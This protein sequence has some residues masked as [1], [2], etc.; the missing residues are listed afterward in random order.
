MEQRKRS[1]REVLA[2]FVQ[3]ARG[4]SAA[5]VAGL[6]HRDFKPGNV[7]VGED[8]R[9]R[10]MDFGLARTGADADVSARSARSLPVVG[11]DDEMRTAADVLLGTPAYMAPEQHAG[12]VPDARAD[13]YAWCVALWEALLGRRPFTGGREALAAAKRAGPPTPPAAAV[14]RWLARLLVRGLAVDPERRFASMDAL[15][16]ALER[17][18]ARARVR[19]VALGVLAVVA[20]AV[21]GLAWNRAE[22]AR[23][24]AACEAA[25]ATIAEVWNDDARAG[26][27]DALVG[28]GVSYAAATA[29]RVMPWL[30]AQ[31]Q[32]WQHAR[33]EACLDAD[34]R[35]VW[36]TAVLDRSSWCLD[37]RRMEIEALV[38]DLTHADATSVQKAVSAAAGLTKVDGCRDAA[39]LESLPAPPVERRDEVREVRAALSRVSAFERGRRFAEGLTV[40]RNARERADALGWPPLAAE[41]G[42]REASVLEGKGEYEEAEKAAAEAYFAALRAGAWDGATAGASTLVPIFGARRAQLAD[43]LAWGRHAESVLAHAND[44]EHIDEATLLQNLANAHYVAGEHAQAQALYERALAIFEQALGTDHPDVGTNL[45]NLAGV[46]YS[47]GDYAGARA[48]YERALAI[49]EQAFGPEHPDVAMGLNNLAIVCAATGERKQALA[50]HERALASWERALGPDHPDV[51]ASLNNIANVHLAL[52]DN[53]AARPLYERSR[54]IFERSLGPD[55]PRVAK[56]V[57]NLGQVHANLGEHEQARALYQRALAIRES[58][59][60]RDHPDLAASLA[61]LARAHL[62]ANQASS[63]VPAGVQ[64]HELAARFAF[65]RALVDSG[66]DRARAVKLAEQ[67]RDGWRSDAETNA[68]V[69][70]EVEAWLAKHEGG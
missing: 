68:A 32:A 7:L 15:L 59:L 6:V 17:G 48:R 57:A 16:A 44:A 38:D 43:G 3:A 56:I 28:T 36:S 14:P 52:G 67:A 20:V 5:H 50:L 62:T 10:V 61:T 54:A 66:G 29:E 65:A 18:L 4:L 9:A 12:A 11:D 41:V 53:A 51:G 19:G 55:H 70:R 21:G 39:L 8:G 35:G 34:V 13:Q 25:G 42:L 24:V 27:R 30:D 23:K 58:A 49:F 26:M 33:T 37:E 31:A 64:P 40:L 1:L 69:L 2:V 60:A 45:N 22:H 63:A 47:V 46:H